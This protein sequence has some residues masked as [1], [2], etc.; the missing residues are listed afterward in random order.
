M[1]HHLRPSRL[2]RLSEHRVVC[3]EIGCQLGEGPLW[4]PEREELLWVDILH[5]TVYRTSFATGATHRW[6]IPENIGWLIPRRDRPGFICGLRSGFAELTLDP[7]EI[8]ALVSIPAHA[9]NTRLRLNDGKADSAGRIFAGTMDMDGHESGKLMRL[10]GDHVLH[11]ADDE[12]GIPNGPT[13]SLDGTRIYHADSRA[14]LVFQYDVSMEG[15][16]TNKR[17]FVQFP[18]DWGV[19]DGMTTDSEGCVWIA[20]WGGSSVSRFSPEGKLIRSIHLPASQITSC[21][22]GGKALD[23]LYVTSAALNRPDEAFAGCVFEVDPGCTGL[24]P[25]RFAG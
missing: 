25:N 9:A 4:L 17:L 6:P 11:V 24:P 2:K 19:P 21:V 3:G 1:S 22:F 18:G 13:F 15:S 20:H 7:F 8:K 10:D 16:L 14:R 5:P 23:R 12:Y